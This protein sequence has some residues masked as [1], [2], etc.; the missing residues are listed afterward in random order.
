MHAFG[1]N[2][3]IPSRIL[4]HT[5][6]HTHTIVFYICAVKN[7]MQEALYNIAQ[8][9]HHVHLVTLATSYYEK[10]LAIREQDYP[11]PKLPCEN[12]DIVENQKLG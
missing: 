4:T 8:A 6:T 5:H 7:F 1:K 2:T 3:P 12:P 10:M 9:Y 11:I